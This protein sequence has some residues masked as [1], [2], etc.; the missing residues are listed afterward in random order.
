MSTWS[1][2]THLRILVDVEKEFVD[3][4][5]IIL[6]GVIC[7]ANVGWCGT[8]LVFSMICLQKLIYEIVFITLV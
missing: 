4:R 1:C 5:I 3:K 7:R 6:V 2:W 8:R